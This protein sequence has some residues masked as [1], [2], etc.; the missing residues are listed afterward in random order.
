MCAQGDKSGDF[1]ADGLTCATIV[2]QFQLLLFVSVS[3]CSFGFASLRLYVRL[4]RFGSVVFTPHAKFTILFSW[5]T[6][7]NQQSA[8]MTAAINIKVVLGR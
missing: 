1:Q 5:H 3:I 8:V 6:C 7:I 2:M 4:G